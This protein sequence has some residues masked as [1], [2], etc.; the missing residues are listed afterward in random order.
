MNQI[1]G[2]ITIDASRLAQAITD[3]VTPALAQMGEQL[4]ALGERL[5]STRLSEEAMIHAIA[6]HLPYP[7]GG[8]A[9]EVARHL[10][11]RLT[12]AGYAL[13]AV[14]G[15]APEAEVAKTPVTPP[16]GRDWFNRSGD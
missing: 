11:E 10:T 4:A 8:N 1:S 9:A 2:S 3:H 14:G 12:R 6:H 5:S 15:Q 7:D 16:T 13:V